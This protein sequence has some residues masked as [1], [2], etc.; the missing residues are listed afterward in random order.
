MV[1]RKAVRELAGKLSSLAG[2]VPYLA[3][4]NRSLHKVS[5]EEGGEGLA[6]TKQIA[7][8]LKW[9]YSVLQWEKGLDISRVYRLRAAEGAGVVLQTDASLEGLGGVLFIRGHPV[10]YFSA[11]IDDGSAFA[12][13]VRQWL[14]VKPGVDTGGKTSSPCWR[15]RTRCATWPSATA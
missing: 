12:N 14:G 8:D 13:S 1:K 11:A 3:A 9:A 6:Y 4:F 2:I 5:S 10:A 15:P 7:H